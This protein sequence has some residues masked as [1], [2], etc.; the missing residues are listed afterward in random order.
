[1]GSAD[2]GGM[3][4]QEDARTVT[5]TIPLP[6]LLS[7]VVLT[8]VLFLG[9]LVLLVRRKG[10]GDLQ[11]LKGISLRLDQIENVSR[12]MDHLSRMFLVPHLRGGLGET[13]LEELL[14]SWLP[15]GSF[16][17]QHTFRS[18]HRADAVIRMG[19]Q[20]V[21]V[22]AKFPMESLTRMLEERDG[23]NRGDEELPKDVQRAFL[24]HIE[25]IGTKYIQPAEGTMSFALM[26]IPSERFYYEAFVRAEH[27][28]LREALKRGV[29]PVS[30][31]SLFLYL[32]TVSFGLRGF[33]FPERQRELARLTGQL[34]KEIEGLKRSLSLTGTHLRNLQKAFDDAFGRFGRVD[35]IMERL[36]GSGS[37]SGDG[38]GGEAEAG[39]GSVPGAGEAG[40]FRT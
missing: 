35:L 30:P 10:G 14:R 3:G 1:M 22:D 28:L 2:A 31:G 13:L 25:D 32:Q 16:S 5:V 21:A 18:G 6:I 23:R 17:L 37:D 4:P 27:Q 15:A 36:D 19:R 11:L 29:V 24:R 33:A 40:S 26:Y 39:S 7:L 20:I 9:L 8:V 34:R 38:P 12:Q